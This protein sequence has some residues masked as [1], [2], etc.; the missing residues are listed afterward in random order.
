MP[1]HKSCYKRMRQNEYRRQLNKSFKSHVRKALKDFR[2]LEDPS[3]RKER[4]PHLLSI[5]DK[6]V[7]KGIYHR[8]KSA[9]LKSRLTRSVDQPPL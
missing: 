4:L 1:E 3:E 9:R 8:N 5:L 7:K 6:A 2:A